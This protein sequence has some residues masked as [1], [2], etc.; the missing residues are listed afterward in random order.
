MY[1]GLLFRQYGHRQE[2]NL[3][4]APNINTYLNLTFLS[5]SLIEYRYILP[6]HPYR[7]VWYVP[8]EGMDFTI[9][10]T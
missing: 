1:N 7:P 5:W 2:E 8:D 4:N 10:D 9:L 3:E 6:F